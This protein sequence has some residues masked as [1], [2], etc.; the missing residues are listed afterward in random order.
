MKV[1]E[2]PRP[3]L[4]STTPGLGGMRGSG[5]E[6]LRTYIVWLVLA[7]STAL[8]VSLVPKSLGAHRKL[9]CSTYLKGTWQTLQAGSGCDSRAQMP[10]RSSFPLI[11]Q[12][13]I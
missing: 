6:A 11:N 3:E 7:Y 2:L 4:T 8:A 13:V 1:E 10:L 5:V 12:A 9:R